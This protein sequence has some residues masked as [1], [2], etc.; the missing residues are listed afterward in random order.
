MK[1]LVALLFVVAL[2]YSQPRFVKGTFFSTRLVNAITTEQLYEN[3]FQFNVGHRFGD[4]Y[5]GLKDFFGLD[6]GASTSIG[7][8][9]GIKDYLSISVSRLSQNKIY[10]VS[11]KVRFFREERNN[12]SSVTFSGVFAYNKATLDGAQ[13]E[14]ALAQL[15]FSKRFTKDFSLQLSPFYIQ[16][17]EN[18]AN[19][20]RVI[21]AQ[22]IYGV[23]LAS[24][25]KLAKRH[26]LVV[27]FA[28][29]FNRSVYNE[30][31]L[32]AFS[33]N[34]YS[35][36]QKY[37]VFSVGYNI[38]AAGH[39]FQIFATNTRSASVISSLIGTNTDI[40]SRHFYLGFN[41]SRLFQF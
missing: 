2:C 32:P 27:E 17:F 9:L 10:E 38:E 4:T 21:G 6:L 31:S 7:F 26:A 20:L 1:Q 29:P 30:N 36:Q 22:D 12:Q 18:K 41:I 16:R 19:S 8:D 5:S 40:S 33:E 23:L 25:Y 3:T 39:T 15:L 28:L 34:F 11:G 24:R 37:N 14:Y 13:D 35:D